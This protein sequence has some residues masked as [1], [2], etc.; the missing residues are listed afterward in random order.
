[1][2]SSFCSFTEIKGL[3]FQEIIVTPLFWWTALSNVRIGIFRLYGQE[4]LMTYRSLM[5]DGRG[6]TISTLPYKECEITCSFSSHS[7]SVVLKRLR[8]FLH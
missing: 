3:A 6:G 8:D 7:I 5:I 1:M 2:E 4:E